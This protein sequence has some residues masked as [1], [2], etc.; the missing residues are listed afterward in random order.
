MQLVG[1]ARHRVITVLVIAAVA[2]ALLA[3][4]YLIQPQGSDGDLPR[5]I[6]GDLLTHKD[7]GKACDAHGR[8][9]N[10]KPPRASHC[11]GEPGRN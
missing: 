3:G 4:V 11:D 1:S 7:E 6:S 10:V 2:V 8:Y 9:G 5:G